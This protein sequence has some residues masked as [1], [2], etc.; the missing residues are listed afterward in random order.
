LVALALRMATM[1]VNNPAALIK[2]EVDLEQYVPR[3]GDFR[4]NMARARSLCRRWAV[5]I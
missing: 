1:L 3:S 2:E 5:S 4:A